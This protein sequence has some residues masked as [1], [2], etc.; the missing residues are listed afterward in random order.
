ML[1]TDLRRLACAAAA[2]MLTGGW[3]G[4]D[5]GSRVEPFQF[6]APWITVSEADR[7]RLDR[8]EVIV[9]T[10]PGDDGQL[11]VIAVTRLN[12]QPDELVA[13][14]RSIAE[15]KRS[16]FVL[17]L[18]PFSDPP[19]LSDLDH[20]VLDER[21]LQAIRECAPGDCSLKLSEPEIESLR[22][23]VAEPGAEWREAIQREFRRLLV[24]RVNLYRAG[25][26]AALAPNANRGTPVRLEETFTAIMARSPY[27]TRLPGVAA[28]LRTYPHAGDPDVE[29]FFYW[30]KEHYG[31]GK[32]VIS[33]TH[34]GIFRL[35]AGVPGPRV[36]VTGKQIFAT[37]Y[38]NGS[39]GLTTV[40]RDAENDAHYL[41]YLNRS[42][43]DLL[44]GFFGPFRRTV[45]EGRVTRDT[46][47][48]VRGLR[49][50]LESGSPP[51]AAARPAW[52]RM[53]PGAP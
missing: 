4:A 8:D 9:R 41:V 5:Y 22:R 13:W 43:I 12:A 33:I 31:S 20:L 26:L 21:D 47:Q 28:W 44:K 35:E 11:A 53:H 2:V 45:L 50:R 17:A 23:V 46:P 6:F 19:E 29:S 51:G 18:R 39:L 15:L 36:L 25:G 3:P 1:K 7:R 34:V 42:Q 40:L 38:M 48:I 52:S 14:T 24:A 10:L 27:L 37:H 30:S 32:P 16:K 49:T